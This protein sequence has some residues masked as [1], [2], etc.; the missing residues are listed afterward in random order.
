LTGHKGFS[1]RGK[2]WGGKI[3]RKPNSPTRKGLRR[4]DPELHKN[5]WHL[6]IKTHIKGS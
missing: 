2:V 5:W 3:V 6:K 1:R 4:E